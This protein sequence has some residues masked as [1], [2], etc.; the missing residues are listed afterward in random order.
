M[1]VEQQKELPPNAKI[2]RFFIERHAMLP[3][4]AIIT[5]KHVEWHWGPT[6]G[7]RNRGTGTDRKP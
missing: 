4:D 1:T 5:Q 3:L 2:A 7:V 6:T